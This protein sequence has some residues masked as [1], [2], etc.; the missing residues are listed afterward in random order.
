MKNN[1]LIKIWF[2]FLFYFQYN[3]LNAQKIKGTILDNYGNLL[4]ATVSI[5]D[6]K[7]SL[8]VKEYFLSKNGNFSF[9]LKFKYESIIVKVTKFGFQSQMEHLKNIALKDTIY[10]KIILNKEDVN[11]LDEIIIKAKKRPFEIKNDT[12]SFNVESYMK[13]NERKIGEIISK[14]PGIEVNEKSG[15]IKYKGKSIEALTLDGD[16][17]FGYNYS[18]ATKNLNVG[19]VES[20]EAIDNY[21]KNPLLKGIEKEGKVALNLKLKKGKTDFS[22]DLETSNGL[23]DNANFAGGFAAS[24]LI[25][26]KKVKSFGNLI[27]NNLGVN[28]APFNF[29]TSS[30]NVEDETEKKYTF[31]KIIPETYINSSLND[32]RTNLNNQFFGS[33]SSIFNITQRFNIRT[34][35]Y[36]LKDEINIKNFS[37]NSFFIENNNFTTTDDI[38]ITK[39]PSY[40]RFDI[41]TNYHISKSS[42]LETSTKIKKEKIFTESNILQN[43]LNNFNSTLNSFNINFLQKINYTNKLSDNKVFQLSSVYSFYDA[44]QIFHLKEDFFNY[45]KRQNIDLKKKYYNI[46]AELLGVK[47]KNKYSLSLGFNNISN[48]FFSRLE[49]NDNSNQS[50]VSENRFIY[51]KNTFYNNFSFNHKKGKLVSNFSYSLLFLE[52]HLNKEI[53][54]TY[55]NN[56]NILFLPT[57]SFQYKLNNYSFIRAILDRKQNTNPINYFFENAIII[58]SRS[59]V[60]NLPSL[61]LRTSNNFSFNY[62]YNNLFQQLNFRSNISFSNINGNFFSKIDVNEQNI[63]TNFFYLSE[64]IDQLNASANI[65][66]YLDFLNSKFTLSSNYSYSEYKNIVNSSELRN[67]I[68]QSIQNRFLWETKFDIPLNF[69]NNFVWNYFNSKNQEWGSLTN[70]TIQNSFKIS[71][72]TI[73][74]LYIYISSDYFIPS[75]NNSKDSYLFLDFFIKYKTKNKKWDFSINF[76]NITNIQ[77]FSQNTTSDFSL[78]INKSNLIPRYFIFNVVW[79]L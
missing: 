24:L 46:N 47:N 70:N 67:N 21:S 36:L 48:S 60:N 57:L 79:N 68:F 51:A 2:V 55:S 8:K 4:N 49:D 27:F 61:Q 52:Q 40:Y 32:S 58:D 13:G 6:F 65:G 33:Y 18:I 59:T 11:K 28:N 41:S 17:L 30:K 7:D 38:L 78:S 12:V 69:E 73:N 54:N 45:E 31:E 56:H 25:V 9:D 20:V 75:T 43:N 76:N 26:N 35:I 14:L 37:Q 44:P 22:A 23:F 50:D 10:L 15:E 34:N 74:N 53:E 39:N 19:I 71:Y 16:D 64:D 66:K 63:N 72:K 62:S 77:Q 3:T 29:S 42:L 5:I 1:L